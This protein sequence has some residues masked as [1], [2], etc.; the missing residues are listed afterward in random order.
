MTPQVPDTP[1]LRQGA[2]AGLLA[3]AA[4][5]AWFLLLDAL[6]GRPGFTP[7]LLGTGALSLFG[8]G[9]VSTAARI[10]AWSAVHV[11]GFAALGVLATWACDA[12]RR[13]PTI[14]AGVL[15]LFAALQVLGLGVIS[16]FAVGTPLAEFAWWELGG[17]NLLAAA[18]LGRCVL[19]R[20]PELW[21]TLEHALSGA[22][23]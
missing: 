23:A 1:M 19:R 6:A 16:M 20:N 2:S 17:A 21:R 3:A 11:A 12:S 14:A 10:V 22:E 8:V 5:A 9:E 18:C 13:E 4:V 7:A 15:V